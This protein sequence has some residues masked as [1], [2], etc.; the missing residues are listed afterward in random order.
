MRF[1]L[2][3]T[4]TPAAGEALV[5]HGHAVHLPA[6]ADLAPDAVPAEALR[7]AAGKQWDILTADP[8]LARAPF[9]EPT[10]FRRSIVFLQ[11]TG[12]DVEQDDAIDRLFKRF[13]RLS[14][15][16]IYTVTESRA[17]VRQLPTA[18]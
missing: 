15:G 5:R 3:G 11:L 17:K 16:R 8:A 18:R 9:E 7:A 4:L 2:H 14:P 6:E 1:L 10:P 13:G 12:G